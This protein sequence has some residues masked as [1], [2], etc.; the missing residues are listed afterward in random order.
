MYWHITALQNLTKKLNDDKVNILDQYFWD[1]EK[2][3]A[4]HTLFKTQQCGM[5]AHLTLTVAHK[6]GPELS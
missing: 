3:A 1:K 5:F 2:Q 4:E 6:S